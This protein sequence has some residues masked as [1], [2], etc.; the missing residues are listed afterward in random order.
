M[1]SDGPR[2]LVFLVVSVEFAAT[3]ALT[4]NQKY[5]TPTQKDPSHASRS[6]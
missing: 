6:N 4:A 3:K 1:P 5:L 2:A